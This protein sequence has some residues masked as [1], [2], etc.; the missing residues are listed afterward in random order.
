MAPGPLRTLHMKK[1]GRDARFPFKP[2]TCEP[3]VPSWSAHH[4]SG[5]IQLAPR[6]IQHRISTSIP[7]RSVADC[8]H[9]EVMRPLSKRIRSPAQ[10]T[11][12]GSPSLLPSNHPRFG[13]SRLAF[14][15]PARAATLDSICASSLAALQPP[16]PNEPVAAVR[17]WPHGQLFLPR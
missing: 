8:L 7:G 16:L 9:I 13:P 3:P 10:S 1:A 6:E 11:V 14:S 15:L 5:Q 2:E 12:G 17:S 4:Q